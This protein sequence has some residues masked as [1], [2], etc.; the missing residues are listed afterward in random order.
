LP[1]N[2]REALVLRFFESSDFGLV[3]DALGISQNAARMRVD[4][5]LE[6]LRSILE[7]RGMTTTSAVLAATFSEWAAKAAPAELAPALAKAAVLEASFAASRV[8]PAV[9][10]WTAAN[11]KIALGAA[12]LG[13]VGEMVFV[14][15]RSFRQTA[16]AAQG[17]PKTFAQAADA[18]T[19]PSDASQPARRD[20]HALQKLLERHDARAKAKREEQ[21]KAML[22]A[23]EKAGS[24][25]DRWIHSNNAPGLKTFGAKIRTSLASG[26]TLLTGGWDTSPGQRT[27]ALTTLT[28]IDAAGNRTAAG[29][30]QGQMVLECR[31]LSFPEGVLDKVNLPTAKIPGRES[32][33][34]LT[35]NED[36]AVKLLQ[37]SKAAEGVE[38]LSTSRMVTLEFR[39]AEISV[40]R[41]EIIE[42]RQEELGI[43]VSMLPIEVAPDGK[44]DLG[45]IVRLTLPANGGLS[46]SVNA[47][48]SR[49]PTPQPP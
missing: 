13:L 32:A 23:W 15:Q 48:G 9:Q 24:D 25:F 40:A 17:N 34:D 39:P 31:F 33:L 26:Q 19:T 7:K 49:N 5:A 16:A 28:Q 27:W 46:S 3:G 44:T 36:E 43:R 10:L 41:N 1:E 29:A 8:S 22:A 12:M 37:A 14:G 42:G 47:G 4:R 35:L 38:T 11:S 21:V 45:I 6:K 18:S 30:S 20:S 2:D